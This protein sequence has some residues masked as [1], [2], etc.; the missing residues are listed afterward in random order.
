M[1]AR[2]DAYTRGLDRDARRLSLEIDRERGRVLD[3]RCDI[4]RRKLLGGMVGLITS[5]AAMRKAVAFPMHGSA[6]NQITN[7]STG[8]TY[9]YLSEA[10]Y[11]VMLSHGGAAPGD[12]IL[13]PTGTYSHYK[14]TDPRWI[15]WLPGD[16][17]ANDLWNNFFIFQ[18]MTLKGVGS[19]NN[20]RATIKFPQC[21]LLQD[22]PNGYSG[23]LQVDSGLQDFLPQQAH[24]L[25]LV[26]WGDGSSHINDIA[27]PTGGIPSFQPSSIDQTNNIL[28]GMVNNSGYDIPSGSILSGP[29]NNG[30]ALFY[31]IGP[32]PGL[33]LQ[34][35]EITG[36]AIY[37]GGTCNPVRMGG[38]YD[39]V[40]NPYIPSNARGALSLLNCYFN[41]CM[42]GVGGNYTPYGWG[43]TMQAYDCEF[44][45]NGWHT[46]HP[47]HNF[48]GH[49]IDEVIFQNLYTHVTTGAHLFKSR[50]RKGFVLYSRDT[51]ETTGPNVGEWESCNFDISDGGLWYI[52]GCQLT[53]SLFA[54]NVPINFNAEDGGLD[55]SAQNPLQE[56]FVI[57]ST[58]IAAS[59]GTGFV[60]SPATSGAISLPNLGVGCPEPV[61]PVAV[62]GSP[63]VPARTYLSTASVLGSSGGESLTNQA[64]QSGFPDASAPLQNFGGYYISLD[65]SHLEQ[66]PSVVPR[67]GAN[68]WNHYLSYQD[69][70]L[71]T[72]GIPV[73]PDPTQAY[74][75]WDSGHTLPVLDQTSGG[76]SFAITGTFTNGSRN[77]TG[78][79]SVRN[80]FVNGMV[81]V[82]GVAVGVVVQSVDRAG[83][84]LVMSD[85][86][87]GTT[88]SHSFTLARYCVV[89]VTYQFGTF[90]SGNLALMGGRYGVTPTFGYPTVAS[91]L[92]VDNGNLLVVK[93]PP[94]VA[95][96]T[97]YNVYV[98]LV[99]PSYTFNTLGGLSKQNSSPI[100]L[101]SDWTEPSTG[102]VIGDSVQMNFYLQNT[103][104][105][106]IGTAWTEPTS[107]IANHNRSRT[108]TWKRRFTTGFPPAT[109]FYAI[110]PSN[111][112]NQVIQIDFAA[113]TQGMLFVSAW[114]GCSATPF[115][116][117]PST[118]GYNLGAGSTIPMA[119]TQ[120]FT[121]VVAAFRN[122]SG[123]VGAGSGFSALQTNTGDPGGILEYKQ[124]SSAQSSITV[125]A[126][127]GTD[128]SQVEVADILVGASSAPT[129]TSS[130]NKA[131]GT[132]VSTTTITLPS[133]NA[134][135]VILLQMT[136]IAGAV[137]DPSGMP[138]YNSA[139]LGSPV[140]VI[141]D[142][143]TEYFN[144]Q[145]AGPLTT[146]PQNIN[147]APYI[148][149]TSC[150]NTNVAAY[151]GGPFSVPV[152]NFANESGD[153]FRLTS[154]SLA[155]INQGTNPG[156]DPNGSPEIAGTLVPVKMNQVFGLPAPGTPIP[157]LV[158]RTDNGVNVGAFQYP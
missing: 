32:D 92:M 122:Y 141:T 28:H 20:G 48:Y 94:S 67:T 5:Y 144:S 31:T 89:S 134:G 84:S 83:A 88:G 90:E 75:F 38:P 118:P 62:S 108:L 120:T 106:A 45:K 116:S 57:S 3:T 54:A 107:G 44:Y 29:A 153:D 1:S 138:V 103:S 7:A 135:D 13:I 111:L 63:S 124:F 157:P 23:D 68:G 80:V 158:A 113:P 69:P 115:D 46:P 99:A 76:S 2:W 33:A 131:L 121:T 36:C 81:I 35:I 27:D 128:N 49:A 139:T 22:F 126:T 100:S 79:S 37:G 140:V 56:L 133:A 50:A 149:V 58:I 110:A 4:T 91:W 109:E 95:G 86:F 87:T 132:N 85:V 41:N 17:V 55:N 51:G 152:P 102:L 143:V 53:Q 18:N 117:D 64:S 15:P 14:H 150:V 72:P 16:V 34:N 154:A 101:S 145:Y 148:T 8:T 65:T 136:S 26:Y 97:G 151:A 114:S 52:I 137:P 77:V 43:S 60:G 25:G 146:N 66:V 129:C 6:V 82:S 71:Y 93:K 21:R 24:D 96:A 61:S 130:A 42:M 155:L 119:S 127:G 10:I 142:C 105:I 47:T 19:S 59:N 9:Q 125:A 78:L 104:P 30:K 11:A 123:S 12:V 112:T 147:L 73:P 39:L 156:A 74:W 40:A 98:N 70:P